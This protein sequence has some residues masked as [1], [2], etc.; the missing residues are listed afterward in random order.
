M[1]RTEAG[2]TAAQMRDPNHFPGIV[3]GTPLGI[4]HVLAMFVSNVTP[5]II[6]AGAA[7]FGFGSADTTDMIYMIQMSMVFAGIATLFQTIGLG[8]VG[9][10]LPVV[11]GT[12]FA[13]VPIM[14][15]IVVQFG[16][17]A[18]IGGVVVGGVFH[19]FL[20]TFIGRLRGWLPPLVTGLVV[21]MIVS[22]SSR[23]A[24]STP[25]AGCP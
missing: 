24:S 5:A 14:I 17:P 25:R 19:F 13:F 8:P 22:P 7:G 12:S 4:Q 21:L 3:R 2:M 20:G 10:R 1:A 11:Q 15:P 18:L 23:S 9:A 16:M 6:V